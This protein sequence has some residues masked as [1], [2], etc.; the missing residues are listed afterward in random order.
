MYAVCCCIKGLNRNKKYKKYSAALRAAEQGSES[1]ILIGG[2]AIDR[3]AGDFAPK[4]KV[5]FYCLGCINGD[6]TYDEGS[7]CQRN[8][9]DILGVESAFVD[10]HENIDKVPIGTLAE[11]PAY[12]DAGQGSGGQ[13]GQTVLLD[14]YQHDGEHQCADEQADDHRIVV[15]LHGLAEDTAGH[16][17]E[18]ASSSGEDSGKEG[19]VY[20][21]A[22]FRSVAHGSNSF[23]VQILEAAQT[24]AA[25]A[26]Q[27]SLAFQ[28]KAA[29]VPKNMPRLWTQRS[30]SYDEPHF[31]AQIKETYD[32]NRYIN[33]IIA[34]LSF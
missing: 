5:A 12:C 9:G 23:H 7:Q 18:N 10:G 11:E 14:D 34:Q 30:F 33:L 26:L 15:I 28:S 8:E 24:D 25:R 1:G 32:L 31:T 2:F 13:R 17:E 16:L 19:R 6:F 4:D 3:N 27:Q 21:E 22:F 20:A 29:F